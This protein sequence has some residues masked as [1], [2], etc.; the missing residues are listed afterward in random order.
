M[1]HSRETTR[2]MVAVWIGLAA[3]PAASPGQAG[4]TV[5]PAILEI[6]TVTR[7]VDV[8]ATVKDAQGRLVTSLG[9]DQFE[10]RE[11]GVPQ[12]VD[13]FAN[14]TDAPLSLGLVIDTSVSQAGLLPTERARA[15]AFLN[16][17]LGPS[18]RAFVM[19]FDQEV[20]LVQ[21]LTNERSLLARAIDRVCAGPG[22]SIL[23]D[24]AESRGPRGTRLFDAV[25]Q[26]SGLLSSQKGRKVLV[27]L[28]D[29]ED[30]GS[31]AT[32]GVA[33]EAVERAEAMVYSVVVAD[34]LFYWGRGRDFS[35]EAALLEFQKRT[36]GWVVRPEATQGLGEIASELRAQYR[37]GYTPRAARFDGS[38]RR[39]E[40]RL[41]GVHDTVRARRGYYAT[42]E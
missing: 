7:V 12:R 31:R 28:T 38:F 37:L 26:A 32:R 11:D 23:V 34:P 2:R 16:G 13:Y 9:R 35:G 14:E 39:I 22:R 30:Q 17:V 4:S 27:L 19:G 18:D 25:E 15:K 3:L 36:G 29:G 42:A 8:Y 6:T 21:G 1:A 20:A 40:V 24:P 10:L 5:P 33:L 41:R